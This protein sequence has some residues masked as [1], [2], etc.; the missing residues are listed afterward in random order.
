F[1]AQ[2]GV[3]TQVLLQELGTI[4]LG[5]S[6]EHRKPIQDTDIEA[7]LEQEHTETIIDILEDSRH[8][9]VNDTNSLFRED[10]NEY[11]REIRNNLSTAMQERF[12]H[13]NASHIHLNKDSFD[14]S[15]IMN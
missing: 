15:R 8:K 9:I 1:L 6:K 11:W 14:P 4:H 13:L 3:D 2:G 5:E 10:M 7:Y 12:P